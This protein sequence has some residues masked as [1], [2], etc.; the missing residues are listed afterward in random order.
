[1]GFLED[2]IFRY[3]SKD[4]KQEVTNMFKE[5]V[6]DDI[7][8]INSE[9]LCIF[10]DM[11]K[12]EP[13]CYW[14]KDV[15]TQTYEN[16]KNICNGKYIEI[17]NNVFE[18]FVIGYGAY[19]QITDIIN[20]LEKLNDSPQI[21]NRLYRIPTYISIIEGCLTNLFKCI[22]L[23][24][25][26]TSSKDYA[27]QRKLGPICEVL[28]KNGFDSLVKDVNKNIRNAIN[29]G[30]VVFKVVKGMH[31]IE[32]IY[33]EKNQSVVQQLSVSDF[34]ELI[35]KVYDVASGVLL[36]ITH[37]FNNNF[38]KIVIDRTSKTYLSF[39]LHAMELSIPSIRCRS[40][41]SIEDNKQLNLDFY[42]NKSDKTFILQTAIELA[43]IAHN[44]YEN[45]KSYFISFSNERLQTSW[46][47]FTNDDIR[48]MVTQKKELTDVI[49]E[50]IARQE[51]LI[52]DA[53][54]EEI[55]LQEVKYFR[56]PNYSNK[57]FKV[58]TVQDAS[59]PDRKRL[60]ANLFIGNISDKQE[61]LQIIN[62]AIQWLK[63]VKNPPSPTIYQKHGT[64]EA[65]SLYINVYREDSRKNKELFPKNDNLVCMIDYNIDGITY[66][67]N[68]GI[69][70]NIWK[71]FYHETIGNIQISWRE[72]KYIIRKNDI[73][74][75]RNDPCPCGSG[76]KYKK[77]CINK[78]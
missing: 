70:E 40:I 54:T 34:D 20:D 3:Y 25:N 19:Q 11:V 22:L 24:L 58:N 1:M 76:K 27:S 43:I 45:Y 5:K 39:Y 33:N 68:G 56:F 23:I 66:L 2:A 77:C 28:E 49:K 47:R 21:K 44:Q 18:Y 13:C 62:E 41:S 4:K 52:W 35:N 50:I 53:S 67:K 17:D 75:G 32:F 31:V 73:K 29:H 6:S 69:F 36:G 37:F 78:K 55:D 7:T 48:Y 26:Q 71:Q 15:Y 42:I 64:M 59:L 12:N 57:K 65:D 63:T 8:F 9:F 72:S 10:N 74:V 38:D 46:I 61:I 30:G 16:L 60:K 51:C 14:D